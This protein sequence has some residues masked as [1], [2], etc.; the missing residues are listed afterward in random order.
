MSSRFESLT[1]LVD[2]AFPEYDRPPAEPMD[3]LRRWVEEAKA[4]GVREPLALALA[5]ADARGRAS[6]RMVAVIDITDRG[7][8]FTSHSSSRKGREIAET[9]WGSGVL[10]W[11]ESGRQ[12]ILSGPIVQVPDEEA[13]RLWA[14]RPPQLHPMSAAS[15]QS[16]PL[17]DA[18]ALQAEADRLAASDGPLPRPAR[19]AGYRLEPAAVEFWAAAATRLHR[20]LR[21]DQTPAGWQARR[22]QP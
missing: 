2:E 15:R 13:E 10:Y 14:A 12:I 4:E 6:T 21:Y 16:E 19:F 18:A 17:E 9:G 22:L 5:T 3:L 20:R 1:G 8:L 11:R 7:A